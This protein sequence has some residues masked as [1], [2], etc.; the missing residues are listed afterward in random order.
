MTASVIDELLLAEVEVIPADDSVRNAKRRMESSALR[1]LIVIDDNRPVGIIQRT[2]LLRVEGEE[3]DKP[4]TEYMITDFPTL[5]RGDTIP[6]AQERMGHDVNVE[7]IPVVSDSGELI[8]AV[9]REQLAHSSTP[10][11]ESPGAPGT[12]PAPELAPVKEGMTVKDASGSKLGSF[13]EADF[14]S[15]GDVEF[16]VVEHGLIFKKQKRLPGDLIREIE[17]DDI[18]LRI[19]SMEWG[20]M[21]DIGDEAP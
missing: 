19:D 11:S 15:Q 18:H 9:H 6:D 13:V 10:A 16:F 2:G 7:E 14:N 5:R 20:M 3:L 1:S 12:G 4:V 21:R 17:E 8:G